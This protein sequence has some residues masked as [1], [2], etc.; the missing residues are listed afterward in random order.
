MQTY[1]VGG[2]VRDQLLQLPVH[3]RDWVVVGATAQQ[4]LDQ[5]YQGV[6]KDFPVF[7]HPRTKE[8]YA[9]ARTERKNG[10]G[11]TGFDCYAS[12][13]VTLEQDLM[14]RDL[15]INAIAQDAQGHL[16]DPYHGQDDLQKKI[17][18]H[19][20][21]AFT[22]DPLRVLRLA[23]F[24]AR[25]ANL[26]F[27]ICDETISLATDISQS[28]EL[29][30]IAAERIWREL[31]K[32]LHTQTPSAFFLAL[33]QVKASDCLIP[34]LKNLDK[35]T[36]SKLDSACSTKCPPAICF[37]VLFANKDKQQTQNLCDRLK[38]PKEFTQL[39][40]LVSQWSNG[41]PDNLTSDDALNLLENTDAF[42]RPDRF[43]HFLQCC[44]IID[45]DA[46][47][48]KKLQQALDACNAV[49]IKAI[50]AQGFKGKAIANKVREQRLE[51]INNI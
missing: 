19:V 32:T 35:E 21:P 5:G 24:L 46:I 39:A 11:Y 43:D 30:T 16:I 15:T 1:L 31:E 22:E 8:E 4:L 49:D 12:P 44:E 25:F 28:G 45:G 14:R 23:R 18:R 9:L 13:D 38:T 10:K 6:G 47:K 51:N 17:L 40:S 29:E 27:S 33:D 3:E 26:G 42:R 41:S 50:A 20:S 34:E 37:A 48:R 36:L 2:A 7:L